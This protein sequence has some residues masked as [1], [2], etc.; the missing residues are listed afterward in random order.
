[1]ST[2]R[3]T[4]EV[5]SGKEQSSLGT[6]FVLL[7]VAAALGGGLSTQLR[8]VDQGYERI[9]VAEIRESQEAAAAREALILEEEEAVMARIRWLAANY[10]R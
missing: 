3:P 5:P 8:W 6:K 7:S 1:M 2:E 4:S 9:H 10:Q